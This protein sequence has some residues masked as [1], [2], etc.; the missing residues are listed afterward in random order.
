MHEHRGLFRDYYFDERGF[1][2][3]GRRVEGGF[4]EIEGAYVETLRVY[5][6]TKC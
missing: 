5:L 3:E 1:L 2:E 6:A 4:E